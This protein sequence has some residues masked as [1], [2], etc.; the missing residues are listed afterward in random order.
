M[1]NAHTTGLCQVRHSV[2]SGHH[3]RVIVNRFIRVNRV[4]WSAP[5]AADRR[6]SG[7]VWR[8]S[9]MGRRGGVA[10]ADSYERAIWPALPEL[11]RATFSYG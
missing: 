7:G 4:N 9:A 8:R 3:R 2:M 1:W 5:A 6:R 11:W 10:E